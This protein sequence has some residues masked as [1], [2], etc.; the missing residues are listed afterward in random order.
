MLVDGRELG[1]EC[2]KVEL[3]Q[4]MATDFPECYLETASGNI[5]GLF[6]QN[7]V[8]VIADARSNLGKGQKAQA[9]PLNADII[10]QTVLRV[11]QPF[12]F[13]SGNT[14]A[15][16]RITIVTRSHFLLRK[17]TPEEEKQIAK[18]QTGGRTSD[19]KSQFRTIIGR[20]S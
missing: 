19:V 12:D 10:A 14:S 13:G 2:Q 3:S 17:P 1:L 6:K 20:A 15:L 4:F 16:S 5:Y 7:D 8:L 11:G 18:E 9:V